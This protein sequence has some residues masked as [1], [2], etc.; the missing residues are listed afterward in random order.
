M[1]HIHIF[2]LYL[3]AFIIQSFLISSLVA[4]S[5]SLASISI[6]HTLLLSLLT[7][8]KQLVLQS[9]LNLLRRM[10]PHI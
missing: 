9:N 2:I 6:L 1:H 7:K 8:D 4:R 3:L 5:F 10:Q